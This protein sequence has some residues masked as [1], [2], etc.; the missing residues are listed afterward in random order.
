MRN[1]RQEICGLRCGFCNEKHEICGTLEFCRACFGICAPELETPVWNL[2][3]EFCAQF[4]E[5]AISNNETAGWPC[6]PPWKRELGND[7]LKPC[8]R[9]TLRPARAPCKDAPPTPPPLSTP[10]AAARS[11]THRGAAGRL[12]GG[13]HCCCGTACRAAARAKLTSNLGCAPGRTICRGEPA[14]HRAHLQPGAHPRLVLA[15]GGTG[16]ARAGRLKP[17]RCTSLL[18]CRG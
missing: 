4:N 18:G 9:P 3:T 10:A 16:S 14:R 5:I 15:G 1:L 8:A 13:T 2:L 12:T 7:N 11:R 17:P 6:S